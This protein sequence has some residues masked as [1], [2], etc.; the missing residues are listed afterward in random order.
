MCE[1]MLSGLIQL[2]LSHYSLT[3]ACAFHDITAGR[4]DLHGSTLLR[5]DLIVQLNLC[6][7]LKLGCLLRLGPLQPEQGLLH[8]GLPGWLAQNEAQLEAAL[9]EA[10]KRWFKTLS[11][12][13][14][15]RQGP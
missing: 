14:V 1:L 2:V 15:E 13:L 3:I 5:S 11:H 4:I 6:A 8:Q 7:A 9:P 12:A 10:A